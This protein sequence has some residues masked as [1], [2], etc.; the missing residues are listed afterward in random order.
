MPSFKFILLVII[1]C[2]LVT[3]IL[4]VIPFVL[5]KKF[6]L[7]R[8]FV[9]FLSFVPIVIMAALWF[10]GLFVQHLGHLPTINIPNLLASIP[11]VI[12]AVISK[13]LL[14]IVAVGIVSLALIRILI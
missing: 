11:T 5:L 10:N 9:Q 7:P 1:G 13:N 2:G 14:V 8:S 6:E 3:W 12:A 4:R